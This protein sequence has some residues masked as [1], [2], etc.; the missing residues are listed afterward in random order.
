[1]ANR[2]ERRRAA[3]MTMSTISVSEFLELP[4]ACAWAGCGK[5]TKNPYAAGWHSMLL[6][7]GQPKLNFLEIEERNMQRDA[8]LCPE[9]AAYLDEH[10]LIDIGGR[11]RETMG[12]A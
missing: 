9:H 2:H 12:T 4:S 6:Y 7:K 8:V 1:M 11:L 10:L 5:A 3:K